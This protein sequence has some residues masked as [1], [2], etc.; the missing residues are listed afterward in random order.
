[1]Q[2]KVIYVCGHPKSGNTWLTRLLGSVLNSPTGGCMPSQDGKEIA[3]EGQDRTGD[4]FIRKGHFTFTDEGDCLVPSPHKMN[5][6]YLTNEKIVF[7]VRDPRDICV[8]GAYHWNTSPED[9]LGRMIRG[10]VANV[11]RWDDY[12][13]VTGKQSS[14]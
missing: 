9:F 2:K 14:H 1:M 6:K 4:Y 7:I 5:L 8:S 12:W 13:I 3:T 10:K 11:G